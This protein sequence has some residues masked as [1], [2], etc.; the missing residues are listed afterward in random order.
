MRKF[1]LVITCMF[2]A[3]LP[4]FMVRADLILE[5]LE[6]LTFSTLLTVGA[7]RFG[8]GIT[9]VG[10]AGTSRMPGFLK[11]LGAFFILAGI[12]TPMIGVENMRALVDAAYGDNIWGLRIGCMIAVAMFGFIAYALAPRQDDANEVQQLNTAPTTGE[13][14]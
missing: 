6:S 1:A 14:Q 2:M 7:L 13:I 9:L 4:F 3:S 12:S 10:A 11:F 8:Y 5:S